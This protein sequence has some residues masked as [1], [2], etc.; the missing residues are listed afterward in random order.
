MGVEVNQ[1]ILRYRPAIIA[2]VYATVG[3]MFP[4]RVFQELKSRIRYSLDKDF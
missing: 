2:R 1:L 4:N 3:S